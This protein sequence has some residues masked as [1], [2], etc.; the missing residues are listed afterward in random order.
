MFASEFQLSAMAFQLAAALEADEEDIAAMV[1]APCDANAYQR[2]SRRMDEMRMYAAALLPVAVAWVE[3]IVP[4]L[5][6]G[7]L[8]VAGAAGSFG[9]M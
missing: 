9:A 6:T 4:P 1:G 5:R 2:A 8:L 7:A 3:V